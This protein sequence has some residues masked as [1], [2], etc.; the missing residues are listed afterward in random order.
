MNDNFDKRFKR[1]KVRLGI[2]VILM[3]A[4]RAIFITAVLLGI[5]WLTVTIVNEVNDRGLK[6]IIEEIWDGPNE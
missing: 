2:G 5:F 4:V 1:T 6:D 3:L